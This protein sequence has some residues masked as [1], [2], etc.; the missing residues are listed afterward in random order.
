VED[1]DSVLEFERDV[2]VGA[3]AQVG[4]LTRFE[5]VK[6]ALDRD[7]YDALI[8]NGRMPGSPGVEE[9]RRWI[10]ENWPHLTGHFLFTFS[11]LAEPEVRSSLELN[12][13]RFLVKP[14]EIGDLISHARQLLMKGRAAHA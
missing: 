2:L 4:T 11:N 14:F 5:E 12:R 1:E 10:L 6:D 9:T 7:N 3:G 13:V 8:M